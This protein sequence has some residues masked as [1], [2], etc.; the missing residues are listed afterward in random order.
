MATNYSNSKI[1]LA[2]LEA[3]HNSLKQHMK[4]VH[5]DFQQLELRWRSFSAVYEGDA[6]DH[7]RAG[8]RRT[9]NMFQDY[10]KQT[11]RISLILEERIKALREA[12]KQEGSF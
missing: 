2:G 7:F 8:W 10:I 1:L 3:Y 6:A 4:Q 5:E 12:N 11:E 9:T